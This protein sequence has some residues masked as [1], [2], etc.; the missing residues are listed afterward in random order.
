MALP[1]LPDYPKAEIEKSLVA[2]MGEVARTSQAAA[3]ADA[4]VTAARFRLKDE[5]ALPLSPQGGAWPLPG[6]SACLGT[7]VG[8]PR[9]THPVP[10]SMRGPDL[11]GTGP[12]PPCEG[13]PGGLLDLAFLAVLA[14][15]RRLRPGYVWTSFRAHHEGK[16]CSK[17]PARPRSREEKK[18]MARKAKK[19]RR[20]GVTTKLRGVPFSYFDVVRR[21]QL[22]SSGRTADRALS[23]APPTTSSGRRGHCATTG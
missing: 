7:V 20:N 5:P 22:R 14:G 8:L 9:N 2:T 4:E 1:G 13:P 16:A 21:R 12:G 15:H 23:G 19:T 18:G 17:S 6:W 10:P 3:K 11:L